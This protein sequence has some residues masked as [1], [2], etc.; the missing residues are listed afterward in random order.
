MN[1]L[2]LK[3]LTIFDKKEP[4]FEDLSFTFEKNN[5]YPLF[6]KIE[7]YKLSYIFRYLLEEEAQQGKLI[8]FTVNRDKIDQYQF[9]E[10]YNLSS[11]EIKRSDLSAKDEKQPKV[12][13]IPV[14]N[15]EKAMLIDHQKI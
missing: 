10:I 13:K 1:F 12:K 14:W 15:Q 6:Y 3:D 4:L 5:L 9:K 2:K 8:L 7:E 11:T